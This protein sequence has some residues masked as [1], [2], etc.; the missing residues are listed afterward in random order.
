MFSNKFN[1]D[2]NEFCFDTA[3]HESLNQLTFGLNSTQES[4]INDRG[5]VEYNFV[6]QDRMANL[7]LSCVSNL[8]I[9]ETHG[10]KIARKFIS[11]PST[12]FSNININELKF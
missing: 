10:E 3:G 1:E 7:K 6:D 9:K 11:E 8:G 5:F 4:F 2:R 12:E